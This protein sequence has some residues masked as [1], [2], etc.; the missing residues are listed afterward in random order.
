MYEFE[1]IKFIKENFESEY[2]GD[3]AFCYKNY[4]VSKDILIENVHFILNNNFFEIGAKSLISNISDIIAMGG[5]AKFFFLGLGLPEKL[6]FNNLK[7]FFDGLKFISN[8]YK[9]ILGGGDISKSKSDF[10]ISITVIGK[11]IKRPILRDN[12]QSGDNIYVVGEV[13][14]S[15]IGLRIIKGEFTCKNRDYFIK[16]HYIK[17]LY[18]E[19]IKILAKNEYINSMID[20]SDGFLQDLGHILENSNKSAE[21]FVKNIPV[22]IEYQKL[23]SILK[24]D[25][26]EIL[27]TSG[28]EYSLIFT[29]DKKYDNKIR[30]IANNMNVRIAKVGKV[31]EKQKEKVIFKDLEIK[32][33]KEG[34]THF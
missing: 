33:N 19:F 11:V 17:E 13:G 10:F 32:L 14:D 15:E 31:I 2:I 29:S 26:Y 25:Y 1:L 28:E 20:I 9:L 7:K 16:K 34:Y 4:L 5:E 22:S 3:D 6:S 27:L 18:P 24:D 30:E 8:K 21:I 12:A 23:K